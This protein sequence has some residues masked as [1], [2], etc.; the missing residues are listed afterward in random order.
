MEEPNCRLQLY[1]AGIWLGG[2]SSAASVLRELVPAVARVKC[3]I[4]KFTEGMNRLQ[5]DLSTILQV[6]RS[7]VLLCCASA[8]KRASVDFCAVG[9]LIIT[10]TN[11]VCNYYIMCTRTYMFATI[12]FVNVQLLSRNSWTLSIAEILWYTVLATCQFAT[13]KGN[14]SKYVVTYTTY[15][16]GVLAEVTCLFLVSWFGK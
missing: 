14:A 16:E 9:H 10:A 11:V 13:H 4:Y 3:V 6:S 12:V 7:I 5:L 1:I 15:Q 2:W 8:A